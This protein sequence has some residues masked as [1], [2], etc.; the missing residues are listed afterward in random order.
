[1]T[2][3][4][5]V[6]LAKRAPRPGLK[7]RNAD[8]DW[9]AFDPEGYFQHY[10]G[11]PHPDDETLTLLAAKAL[12]EARKES[13]RGL[14][15]VDIGTGPSLIPLLA[16]LP[17]AS[18]LTAWEYA[19]PNLTW[20]AQEIL[21]PTLRSQWAHFW[22]AAKTAWSDEAASACPM[23]PHDPLPLLVQRTRLVCGSIFDLPRHSFDAATMFFCAESITSSRAE[24]DLALAA[25]TGTVR[26]GGHI[27]AA[28]LAGSS[29]YEVSGRRFPAVALEPGEIRARLAPRLA[30][31]QVVPI[32]LSS[33][34]IRSG[35]SGAIFVS[36][37]TPG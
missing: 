17:A 31:L 26:P 3:Q 10:Y 8:A 36:G 12:R 18:K 15:V 29:G 24:F 34:E 28:F 32:G 30:S 21:A 11:D 20:L 23:L 6:R 9:H 22:Q 1:M 33:Q 37:R 5:A 25:F 16:A 27:A 4:A 19:E 35:Y 14:D 13:P 2:T 7:T